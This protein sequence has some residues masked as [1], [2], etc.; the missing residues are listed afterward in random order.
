MVFV[1]DGFLVSVWVCLLYSVVSVGEL[2]VCSMLVC[3]VSF[4][5]VKFVELVSMC[6]GVGFDGVLVMMNLLC[7]MC[8]WL[9]GV[10]VVRFCSVL[11]VGWFGDGSGGLFLCVVV[12][13]L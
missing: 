6:V 11:M 5:V 10:S 8:V 3:L 7:M 2:N 13:V 9:C 1:I 4:L 12:C